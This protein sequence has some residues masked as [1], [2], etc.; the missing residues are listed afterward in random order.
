AP[1]EPTQEL[2]VPLNLPTPPVA[3]IASEPVAPIEPTQELRV[4][5]NLPTPP[6]APIASEPVA[7]IEPTQEPRVPLILPTPP[8]APIASEPVAP[9]EPTQEPRVPLILPTTLS[10]AEP[11]A[12]RVPLDMPVIMP[13]P[14]EIKEATP[15]PQPKPTAPLSQETSSVIAKR[16]HVDSLP[17]ERMIAGALPRRGITLVIQDPQGNQTKLVSGTAP[18]YGDGG[19]EYPATEDGLYLVT[20]GGRV[21]EVNVQG[22]TAFIHAETTF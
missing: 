20:I 3:P 10:S 7:P 11:L 19:F 9:I 22:E 21:I 4:P 12:P 5:L 13:V 6:V 18:Q 17:G 1:V 14:R 8:V 15:P 16:V 2:R